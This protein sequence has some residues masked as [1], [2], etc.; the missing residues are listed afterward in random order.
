MRKGF[1][2][3]FELTAVSGILLSVATVALLTMSNS[4]GTG[5]IGEDV[6]D[7]YTSKGV[8]AA[9]QTAGKEAGSAAAKSWEGMKK[10]ASRV[11]GV[12]QQTPE[13]AV[14]KQVGDAVAIGWDPIAKAW[15]ERIAA[16]ENAARSVFDVPSELEKNPCSSQSGHYIVDKSGNCLSVLEGK[17]HTFTVKKIVQLT[18]NPDEV[19]R[20]PRQAALEGK[21]L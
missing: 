3:V 11:W 2:N 13:Y 21:A 10:D 17:G 5:F 8:V 18:P 19:K 4:K 12:V 1:Q 16:L 15:A 20:R 7:A 6:L 9:F 14:A